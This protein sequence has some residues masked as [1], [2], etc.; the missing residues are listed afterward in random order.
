MGA[1][2]EWN[3]GEVIA[4]IASPDGRI[5]RLDLAADSTLRQ[6]ALARVSRG[7]ISWYLRISTRQQAA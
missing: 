5:G 2:Y 7:I 3:Q 4:E 6:T 1:W